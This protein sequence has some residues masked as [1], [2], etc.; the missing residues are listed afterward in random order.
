MYSIIQYGDQHA[1][2]ENHACLF[3]KGKLMKE[4][5]KGKGTESDKCYLKAY[6]CMTTHT[7]R[8]MVRYFDKKKTILTQRYT[9][10]RT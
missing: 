6:V 2:H 4:N 8:Y 5:V 7:G 1:I 9:I 10:F 3:G